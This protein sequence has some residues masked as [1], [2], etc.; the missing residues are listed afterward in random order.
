MPLS[1][2]R[3]C[4]EPVGLLGRPLHWLFGCTSP[5]YFMA[6]FFAFVLCALVVASFVVC[7]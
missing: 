4:H 6:V 7:R 2:C 1:Q 5:E 3:G